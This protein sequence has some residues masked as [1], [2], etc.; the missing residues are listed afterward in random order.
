MTKG[1]CPSTGGGTVAT[2]PYAARTADGGA[3]SPEAHLTIVSE[4][5]AAGTMSSGSTKSVQ[6][7]AMAADGIPKAS[8]VAWSCAITAPL[9][10]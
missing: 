6:P 7:V 10:P 2:A 4:T 9:A 5:R 8:E 1:A 3:N